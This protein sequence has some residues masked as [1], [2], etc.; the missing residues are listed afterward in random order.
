MQRRNNNTVCVVTVFIVLAVAALAIILLRNDTSS[1]SS[2]T[3][4]SSSSSTGSAVQQFNNT[5][6]L[7]H[8]NA[9]SITYPWTLTGYNK[10]NNRNEDETTNYHDRP[11]SDYFI[12]ITD[13]RGDIVTPIKSTRSN[14]CTDSSKSLLRFTLISDNYPVRFVCNVCYNLCISCVHMMVFFFA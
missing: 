5:S 10:T 4:D 1:N 3:L 6:L 11:I 14:K 13:A 7:E 9:A 8:N 12:S 2:N